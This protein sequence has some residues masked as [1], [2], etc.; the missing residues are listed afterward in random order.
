MK[1]SGF[2]HYFD[3]STSVKIDLSVREYISEISE[4]HTDG[5]ANIRESEII[6]TFDDEQLSFP[7][8]IHVEGFSFNKKTSLFF[9]QD[10]F[11]YVLEITKLD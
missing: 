9:N 2:N 7:A 6:L 3:G 4:V 10:D 5:V 1:L 8:D 11:Y